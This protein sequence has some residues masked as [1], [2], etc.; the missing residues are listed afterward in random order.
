MIVAP[1]SRAARRAAA[2]SAPIAS[3]TPRD[4]RRADLDLGGVGLVARLAGRRSIVASTCS[5]HG[6]ERSR[7]R[8][9]A[10][11]APPRAD[12]E[13]RARAEACR[14]RERRL[15]GGRCPDRGRP[16]IESRL[17]GARAGAAMALTRAPP[18]RRPGRARAPRRAR[19]RSRRWRC[20]RRRRPPRTRRGPPAPCSSTRSP[21][22]VVVIPA[23][24]STVTAPSRRSHRRAGVARRPRSSR[25]TRALAHPLAERARPPPGTRRG[26]AAGAPSTGPTSIS[27]QVRVS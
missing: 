22:S 1:A 13:G 2:R 3:S 26:R 11:A 20:R 12:G 16:L 24:T 10:G 19:S 17:M 7:V 21:P 4:D 18:P 15:R 14:S 25:R 9:D 23:T 5:A 6:R 8:V 27:D